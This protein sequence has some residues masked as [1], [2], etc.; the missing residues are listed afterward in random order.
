M[1]TGQARA[2]PETGAGRV[3]GRA[4]A[5]RRPSYPPVMAVDDAEGA[6][7]R[8]SIRSPGSVLSIGSRGSV[9]SIGSIGS[10]LS[11]GSVGSFGSVGSVGSFG[12]V[13]AV[14]SALSFWSVMS[15]RGHRQILAG[16]PGSSRR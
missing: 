16:S 5:D 4:T 2:A 13:G 15:W 8:W 12:S 14:L 1:G 3:T 6:S 10:A 9:L 11:I 7:S